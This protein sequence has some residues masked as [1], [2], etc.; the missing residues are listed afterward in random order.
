MEKI[1]K[2]IKHYI[3]NQEDKVAEN[4]TFLRNNVIGKSSNEIAELLANVVPEETGGIV[5]ISGFYYQFLVAIEYIIDMLKDKWDYIFIEH[6]DDIVVG[7]DNTVRFVQ[8][9][10]SEKVKM[11]ATS[12]P[13]SGLYYRSP[14]AGRTEKRNDSWI[15]KLLSK[16]ELLQQKDGYLTQFQLYSSYHI[17]K[18]RDFDFD[19][20]TGNSNYDLDIADTDHLFLKVSAPVCDKNGEVY[21][22]ET[23]CGEKTK[24]LLRRFYLHTGT[25]L[26]KLEVFEDHLCMRLSE[27]L[28]HDVGDRVRVHPKD[29]NTLIGHLCTRCTYRDSAERLL[30]TRDKL[31]EILSEIRTRCLDA[32]EQTTEKHGNKSTISRVIDSIVSNNET[33]AHADAFKDKLYTYREYLKQWVDNGGNIRSLIERY[34][35]GT[36]K[37]SAYVNLNEINRQQKLLDFFNIVFIMMIVKDSF[38]EFTDSNN[39]L[40][41]KCT[42]S[43]LLFSFLSLESRNNLE[44]GL[45]KLESII[46]QS[47]TNDHLYLLD[48]SLRI[49]F[50]NYGDRRFT[51][52]VRRE[53]KSFS[54][55]QIEGF[56]NEQP[57]NKVT[58][59]VDIIPG[60]EMK[61]DFSEALNE[62]DCFQ[63]KMQ[64]IWNK[65]C[66]EVR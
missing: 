42:V 9:K 11:N 27:W 30:I 64:E 19:V 21:D 24:E 63:D 37:S 62:Q 55:I 12:S 51:E 20:Y 32:V 25:G 29:L 52:T 15:D 31:E 43:N 41:K 4:V 56:E 57:L 66:N 65:Y 54:E 40:T 33:C 7:K 18:T 1:D 34:V 49:V 48:K 28:F 3:E 61:L 17:I 14:I 46:Q 59:Y 22:Y 8:V 16:A 10:T 6:L 26:Q 60:T 38:L 13:A 44:A 36:I 23:K 2:I 50:Q 45:Q 47:D 39:L 58:Y 53:I 5:A 35:D